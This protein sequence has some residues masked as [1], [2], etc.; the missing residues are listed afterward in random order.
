VLKVWS[1]PPVV[2]LGRCGHVRMGAWLEDVTFIPGPQSLLPSL[3]PI[4]HDVNNSILFHVL[5][6]HSRSASLGPRI[7]G[8]K[9]CELNPLKQ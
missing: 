3:L 2:L 9:D 1:P 7:N 5:W 8:A 6:L 4:C